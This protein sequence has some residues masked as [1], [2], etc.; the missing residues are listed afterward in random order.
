M[1]GS[2]HNSTSTSESILPLAITVV[3]T[4]LLEEFPPR[5]RFTGVL[6]QWH[7]FRVRSACSPHSR[8]RLAI[9]IRL[10]YHPR[11]PS[12]WGRRYAPTC[13]VF[14]RTVSNWQKVNR[15]IRAKLYPPIHSI[16]IAPLCSALAP[17]RWT[18]YHL[19]F[20][21]VPTSVAHGC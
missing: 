16:Y 20:V 12:R 4:P 21:R 11:T 14:L 6:Q 1:I 8:L 15:A 9:S 19:Y 13:G 10:A 3:Y 2:T 5:H 17:Q 18:P 7:T